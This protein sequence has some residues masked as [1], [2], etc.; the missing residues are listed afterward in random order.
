MKG[1]QVSNFIGHGTIDMRAGGVMGF[2]QHKR[3][4]T[5]TATATIHHVCR[6][7]GL[8]RFVTPLDYETQTNTVPFHKHVCYWCTKQEVENAKAMQ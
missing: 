2:R 4:A 5:A 8:H 1:S 6:R 7:C 3:D